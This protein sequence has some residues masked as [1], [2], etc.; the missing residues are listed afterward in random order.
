MPWR[1][2]TDV[3]F[4][5]KDI[6]TEDSRIF[7]QALLH[8]DGDYRVTP[9]YIPVSM[10]TVG[11]KDYAQSLKNLYRQQRRWAWGVEHFPY[12][13]WNFRKHPNFPSWKKRLLIGKLTEGMYSWATA[14][15]LMFVLGH[16]PLY[17]TRGSVRELAI[18]QNAPFTLQ[19]LMTLAMAGTVI[20]A[21]LALRMMPPRPREKQP[22]NWLVMLAQWALLPV[23]FI[24]FGSLPATDAQ[25]RLMLGKYLGFNVSEKAK[26]RLEQKQYALGANP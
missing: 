8:Y 25:T 7:L 1:A 24:L 22:W 5:Q 14:P 3:G 23:T 6:V 26:R 18:V 2:L 17:L 11:G 16:L 20:S 9:L 12:L 19:F 4:W 13:M 21:F 15:V 10:D